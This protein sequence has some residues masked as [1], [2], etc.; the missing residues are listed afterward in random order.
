MKRFVQTRPDSVTGLGHSFAVRASV[1]TGAYDDEAGASSLLVRPGHPD[2]CGVRKAVFKRPCEPPPPGPSKSIPSIWNPIDFPGETQSLALRDY[3]QEK[4][5]DRKIDVIVANSHAS[6]S[7]L[8]Q[9]RDVRFSRILP[10]FSLQSASDLP[11][12]FAQEPAAT[13][14]VYMQSQKRHWTWR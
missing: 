12:D 11:P 4:Y 6:L 9:Y 8:L 13:G 10:S 3:L 2:Q 7:F 14:I 5:A 1:G